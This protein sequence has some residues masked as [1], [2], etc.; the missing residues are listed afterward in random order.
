MPSQLEL[1]R[2][3]PE[4]LL[5]IVGTFLMVLTPIIKTR[6]A[7]I[8]GNISLLAI[9]GAIA[10]S[11]YAFTMPGMA[12]NDMLIVDSFATFFR[13]LVLAVGAL[14]VLSSYRFLSRDNTEP[15][16]FH[17][18]ILF[19]LSGQCLMVSANSLIMIFIGL[20]ISSI[21][22]Y[23]LCGYLRD[24]K[25][26]NESALKYFLLGSSCHGVLSSTESPSSTAPPGRSI[27]RPYVRFSP[28][29]T[30]HPRRRSALPW[31]SCS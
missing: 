3:L 21:A 27:S 25:R 4:L 18:L 5:I 30:P 7:P 23:I 6:P 11:L 9:F 29:P 14:T 8:F 1:G 10:A 24:D 26:A 19:S 28:V 20:E 22:T 17:A 31:P 2:F 15:G 16:E 12:F 13:V